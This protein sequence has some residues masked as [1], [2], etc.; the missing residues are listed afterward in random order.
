MRGLGGL[1]AR[2]DAARWCWQHL[3]QRDLLACYILG[4]QG[5]EVGADKAAEKSRADVVRMT[6]FLGLSVLDLMIYLSCVQG[7][8]FS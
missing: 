3:A 4:R 1:D 7:D 2:V 6:F 8:I 5:L